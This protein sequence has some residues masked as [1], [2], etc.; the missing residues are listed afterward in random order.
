MARPPHFYVPGDVLETGLAACCGLTGGGGRR[1]PN[2]MQA[3]P[4]AAVRPGTGS[5]GAQAQAA[6][7]TPG[8]WQGQEQPAPT[9]Q[10]TCRPHEAASASG[11]AASLCLE[12]L[13]LVCRVCAPLLLC[14]H[15]RTPS[16]S[17][18]SPCCTPQQ[19]RSCRRCPG[20]ACRTVMAGGRPIRQV[21]AGGDCGHGAKVLFRRWQVWGML[22]WRPNVLMCMCRSRAA[23]M[24]LGGVVTRQVLGLC[25][26]GSRR[27]KCPPHEPPAPPSPGRCCRGRHVPIL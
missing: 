23:K 6:S 10:C 22:W 8:G 17:S 3:A 14:R 13:P 27:L 7:G 21:G 26:H 20:R 24:M 19:P 1:G 15:G 12:P 5:P 11:A 16:S 9:R 25:L 18:R 2:G 4:A